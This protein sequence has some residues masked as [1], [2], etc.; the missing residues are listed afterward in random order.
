MQKSVEIEARRTSTRKKKIKN[1]EVSQPNPG[2]TTKH[3][4]HTSSKAFCK[5]SRKELTASSKAIGSC[6]FVRDSTEIKN[7]KGKKG[8]RKGMEKRKEGR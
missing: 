5:L 4:Q 2:P 8:K 6:H 3:I 1:P 7:T